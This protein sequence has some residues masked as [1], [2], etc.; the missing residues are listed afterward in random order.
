MFSGIGL[1]VL[2]LDTR[3]A[4]RGASEGLSLCVQTVIPSLF[5]AFVLSIL[6]TDA[7]Q[8][9][10]L[11]LFAPLSR[12]LRISEGAHMLLVTGFLGGYPIGAKCTAES[13]RKGVITPETGRRMLAFCSNAG[14]AFLFGIGSRIF[15]NGWMC[16]AAWI[17]HIFSA[18]A[19]AVLLPATKQEPAQFPSS[20]T[21]D[22]AS[23]L[24]KSLEAMA[25]VSAWIILFRVILTFCS[26]WF[27][28]LLP[29]W[30][31]CTFFGIVELTNGCCNLILLE[32]ERIRF[33]LFTFFLGFGGLCVT[34]QT[35]G[36]CDCVDTALYLPGKCVQAVIS[37]C[38]AGLLISR[39]MITSVLCILLLLVVCAVF[40]YAAGKCKIPLAFSGKTVYYKEKVQVR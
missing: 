23:A 4:L 10:Q 3:T 16:W 34:M 32:D 6:L 39:E 25:M 13:V 31:S 18:L 5:P 26:V 29:K 22:L 27:L 2:I 28:W 33:V 9:I 1:L 7:F 24:R 8:G 40:R 17:I 20:D 36:V 11:P 15:S 30:V 21:M 37:S 14:P 12:I 19:V 35:F 38:L